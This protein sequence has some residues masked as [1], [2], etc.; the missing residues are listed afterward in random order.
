MKLNS[1]ESIFLIEF[2]FIIFFY[3]YFFLLT[4]SRRSV[5]FEDFIPKNYKSHAHTHIFHIRVLL[6]EE[7]II[8]KRI[9][10]TR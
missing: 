3:T 2:C 5:D 6:Q 7:K 1:N 9:S 8:T 4:R 10:L